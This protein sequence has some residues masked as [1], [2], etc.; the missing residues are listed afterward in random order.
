MIIIRR[1]LH[2]PIT[3]PLP[4]P[5]PWF[6]P[7]DIVAFFAHPVARFL[8]KWFKTHYVGCGPCGQRQQAMNRWPSK[9]ILSAKKL[10]QQ[11]LTFTV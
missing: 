4:P 6:R 3:P 8:D 5:K 7:G 9:V 2:E 11:A 1:D 10:F